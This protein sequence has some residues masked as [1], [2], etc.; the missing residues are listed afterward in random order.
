MTRVQ[1][2]MVLELNVIKCWAMVH[3][4]RSCI[5]FIGRWVSIE[6]VKRCMLQMDL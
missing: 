1:A 6:R 4:M 5:L 3:E 2:C